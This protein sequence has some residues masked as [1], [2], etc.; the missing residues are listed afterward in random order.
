VEVAAA[1]V[2]SVSVACAEAPF[3]AEGTELELYLS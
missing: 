1:K 3:E 2:A